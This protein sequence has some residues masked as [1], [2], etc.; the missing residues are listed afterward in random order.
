MDLSRCQGRLKSGPGFAGR[1]VDH[2]GVGPFG[3]DNLPSE[4]VGSGPS[5]ISA[6]N[7]RRR[8]RQARW[9]VCT[10][11]ARSAT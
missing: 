10:R 3:P 4:A 7:N 6:G 8:K 5:V 1:K 9:V 11:V 2:L